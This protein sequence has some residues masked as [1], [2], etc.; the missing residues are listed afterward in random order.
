MGHC[1][2]TVYQFLVIF[3]QTSN[4]EGYTMRITYIRLENYIGIYNGRG[5]DILEIDLSQN[6]NPIVIIRGTNGS[7]KSTLLKSLTPI[8]DDSNAIVPGVTG[9]KVIRYLHN[10]ITYEIEYVHPIDKEGKRKQTRGQVYKYGPNGKEELNPTWNVSSAKDIIYS[11]FNLD[12][13]FLALSQ[14]SSEDRGLADKRPAERKSFVSSI[15]SGI[16]AYNAMY[17]IISKKHSMY[18]SLIQSLTAKINRIGNKE[19]L[20]LKLAKLYLIEMHLYNV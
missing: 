5:D 18:K 12:S 3:K 13:N 11:L 4:K 20:D 16:E 8:N 10:G 15:I 1:S 7:G 14:L 2:H 17:K 9:R 19:D 6:V